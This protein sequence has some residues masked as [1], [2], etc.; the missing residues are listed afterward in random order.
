MVPFNTVEHSKVVPQGTVLIAG[1]GPVGLLL[2]KVLSFY[3]VKSILFDRNKSTTKW[4]KMD[5]TNVRSMELLRKLGIADDLRKYG[6]PGDIDQNVLV[7]SGL[8]SDAAM[9]QWEL[10]G[11]NALRQRIKERNDGSQ[12]LEPWQRLSQVIFERR[13]RAMCEDDPLIQLHYSHKIESVELQPAGVK[14]RIIDSETGIS[15]VW[16]SDYVAGCDGASSR[17]RKSLSFPL[18]GGPIPSCALLV[19]FKSRDLSR[20]HKQGRFWHIL[21]VG[22]SGGF[23]GVAIAQDEIDTWTT[24]LFMPLDANPDALESYEAVYKVLGGLYGPYEIKIDEV[25]VRSVWRPN[26]AVARTWSSPCQR[27]FLA[28]DAAH[29]NI[30]TGGYGMNM[31]IGDAFDLGWKLTS[32]INGQSGQTLLKSYEL[33]RKPVALRNVDHSGEHFQVHQ[34]LKELLGGGDPKRVDHDTEEGRNLRRKIHTYYQNND[35]ENKNFGIEM[36]YRYTSPVIIRQKDDGVEPIWTPRHYHPTTWPGSRVPHLFLSDGTP[37][38]D[39]IG[40]HWTLILFDSQ[41]PDLHHFVDA[42]NQLGIPLSIVDLSEETQAKELY[43][44]ALVLIRPD[45]HAAWRADEVPPF[46][47][48]R[49]VLLTVTGRLSVEPCFEPQGLIP[50]RAFTAS[51][52]MTT[53]VEE[54]KLEKM[55]GFQI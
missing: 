7:S 16:E 35:G 44:K 53:Q 31:G 45:Q 10:P 36:G 9:T 12:P 34:K 21:L 55:G 14:T 6:V 29:Q 43:E 22:E 32:V 1:G 48:T 19:H 46:E 42:A 51:E 20:L 28:G 17:V 2:A 26:I 23:E 47:A 11:A 24:H 25:L 5:L 54:F 15:T 27:V 50:Q 49:H 40:K 13:L 33:E 4:P 41:L 18:D 39:L 8:G 30:P 3:D 52:T 37:I 38:F